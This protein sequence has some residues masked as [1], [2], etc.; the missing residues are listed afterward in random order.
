MNVLE[1]LRGLKPQL[2]AMQER[3]GIPAIF[4]AAQFAHEAWNADGT[5]SG[6]SRDWHNHAGIK[7]AAWESGHGAFPVNMRTWE[8]LNGKN[9]T[10]VDAFAGLTNDGAFLNMYADLLT[11]KIYGKFLVYK[12]DPL[13]YA[14][15]VGKTWA[16][17]PNYVHGIARWMTA[18]WDE[19]RDTLPRAQAPAPEPKPQP[20]QVLVHQAG[21]LVATGW[22]QDD[23]TVVRL[24]DL[25]EALG[26]R[27]S[28]DAEQFAAILDKPACG[29]DCRRVD[30]MAPSA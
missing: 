11:G 19:W 20:R 22:I 27:V 5:Q 7:W 16:T 8:V 29:C 26:Y 17:D 18:L 13:L 10:V 12:E 23:S 1:W 2:V 9:A 4:A 28:W 21:K 24:R 3:Y 30:G 25:A 15:H 14:W 6:L